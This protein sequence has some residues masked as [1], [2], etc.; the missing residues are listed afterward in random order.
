MKNQSNMEHQSFKLE[1]FWWEEGS[2]IEKAESGT[3]IFDPDK[4]TR[5]ITYKYYVKDRENIEDF[6]AIMKNKSFNIL[7]RTITGEKVT[8]RG[9]RCVS[10]PSMTF[11]F[12]SYITKKEYFCPRILKG[13]HIDFKEDK[14]RHAELKISSLDSWLNNNIINY[15]KANKRTIFIKNRSPI[16]IYIRSLNFYIDFIFDS[17]PENNFNSFNVK[18]NLYLV[19][20]PKTKQCI[21][22][23]DSISNKLQ[24]FMTF[25]Y[26]DYAAITDISFC[27]KEVDE[28]S[29]IRINSYQPPIRKSFNENIPVGEMF[30][31]FHM[32]SNFRQVLNEWFK[33]I[34]STGDF[35]NLLLVEHYHKDINPTLYFL[36]LMQA[37]ET[38]HRHRGGRKTYIEDYEYSK[39]AETIIAAI[40]KTVDPDHRNSLISRINFGNEVSLRSRMKLL[41]KDLEE[42][43]T[44]EISNNLDLFV[45]YTIDTRN[46]YTHYPKN[47][48]GN[49]L[50]GRE[51]LILNQKI[52][53]LLLALICVDLGINNS[54]TAYALRNSKFNIFYGNVNF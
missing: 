43:I 49:V 22:W 37:L 28:E 45:N 35:I 50:K 40:P 53:K 15:S 3:L 11:P 46:Y 9:A 21:D 39:I 2:E 36:I 29:S 16:S 5:L 13:G 38:Y 6:F 17:N 19:I 4:Y 42:N 27:H 18:S 52:K 1:G 41:L 20:R 12:E 10:G 48:D 33:L 25:M 30:M 23:Y 32:L 7:G 54:M 44:K 34:E 31:S 8:L 47:F 26:G 51:L 24:K 14:F